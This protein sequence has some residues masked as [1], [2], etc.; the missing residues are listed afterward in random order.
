MNKVEA[1]WT[2]RSEKY[3]EDQC[4]IFEETK[5]YLLRSLV[6][7][8]SRATSIRAMMDPESSRETYA[9]ARKIENPSFFNGFFP[10][11][12]LY[13]SGPVTEGNRS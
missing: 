1:T 5:P 3:V 11:A 2:Q 4:L 6:G 9:F 13:L 8:D 12:L 7:S 10:W